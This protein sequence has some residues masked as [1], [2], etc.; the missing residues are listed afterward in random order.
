MTRETKAQMEQRLSSQR[1]S[2]AI[3]REEFDKRYEVV[4]NLERR[5]QLLLEEIQLMKGHI[6]SLLDA[7]NLLCLALNK[8]LTS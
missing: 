2:L 5:N 7:H 6:H 1:E 8:E 3:L 4:R